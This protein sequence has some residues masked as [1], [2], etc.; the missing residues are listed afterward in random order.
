[1]LKSYI[2]FELETPGLSPQVHEIIEIG[3]LKVRD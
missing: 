1:M 3:A 2:A